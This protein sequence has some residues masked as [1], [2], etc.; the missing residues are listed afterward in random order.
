M[1][2]KNIIMK[3]ITQSRIWFCLLLVFTFSI[4]SNPQGFN[5]H[6]IVKKG[7]K[8]IDI[9]HHQGVINWDKVDNT[10]IKFVIIKSTEGGNYVDSK[11]KFNWD[12]SRKKNL[13]VGAYHRF[14][15]K[16][17]GKVQ[18]K[19]Y[20]NTVPKIPNSIPPLIDVEE[21]W[22]AV[23]MTKSI[24]ELKILENELYK[25]YGKKPIIYLDEYTYSKYITNNFKKNNAWIRDYD[26]ESPLM[27]KTKK[28]IWQ[29]TYEGKCEGIKGDVD[30]NYF[31]GNLSEF[32]EFIK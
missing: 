7:V 20:I 23:D 16:S 19:N 10:E 17:S 6:N 1:K 2:I 26:N 25:Y 31:N 30:M 8:G 12:K 22:D 28:G 15:L 32:K 21:L 14:T 27:F 11:F 9:S 13:I 18:S 3:K 4:K 29:Y 24:K 5:K